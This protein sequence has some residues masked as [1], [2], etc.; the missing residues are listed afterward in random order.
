MSESSLSFPSSPAF[1]IYRFFFFMMAILTSVR[2]YL[3]V[4]LLCISLIMS[5]IEHLFLCLL[6]IYMSLEKSPFRSSAHF[7]DWVVCFFLILS[8]LYILEINPLSVISFA[9]IFSH[10]EDCLFILFIV[11]SAVQKL[12]SL[13]RSHWFIFI[14]IILEGGS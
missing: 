9:M 10:C 7:F 3:I 14:S 11:S 6:T 5:N 13:I 2:W 1:I 12:L 8:C 4:V